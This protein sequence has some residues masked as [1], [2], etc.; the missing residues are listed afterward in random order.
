[1]T[2]DITS[3]LNTYNILIG[4]FILFIIISVITYKADLISFNAIFGKEFFLTLV[5]LIVISSII[6]E[7]IIFTSDPSNSLLRLLPY[8]TSPYFLPTIIILTGLISLG[9]FFAFLDISEILSKT[10]ENNTAVIV[11]LLFIILFI[12]ITIFTLRYSVNKDEKILN[13]LP[14]NIANAYRLRTY[15][16]I[17]FFVFVLLITLLY[18]VNPGNFM[19]SYG[20]PTIFFV[21]FI[22]LVM[23]AMITMYQYFL[24]NQS[25]AYL[26]DLIPGF[27]SFIIKGL[28]VVL[29]LAISGMLIYGL[30]QMLD[31][32]NQDASD[33]NNWTHYIFNFILLAS[34]LGILYKLIMAGGFIEKS[35]IFRLVVNTIMYIPCILVYLLSLIYSIFDKNAP[36]E[37]FA[38]ATKSEKILLGISVLLLSLYFIIDRLLVPFLYKKITTQGGK[39]YINEPI[40][41]DKQTNIA[42]YQILNNV[43]E[44]DKHNYNFALSFWFYIDSFPPSTNTSYT[45]VV[46]ILS[47]GDN[48]AIKYDALN[49]TLFVSVKQST[50]PIFNYIRENG[51]DINQQNLKNWKHVKLN[52]NTN[53]NTNDNTNIDDNNERIIYKTPNVLLQ[54]W[55]NITINSTGGTLDIFYNGELV[56]SATEVVPYLKYDML[57]VGNEKGISG[58]LANLVYFTNPISA[59]TISNIYNSLKDKN[60]PIMTNKYL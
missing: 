5:F 3:K 36:S 21:L 48:P 9:G 4:V 8:N 54:K 59:L 35:P 51:I 22:G 30:L 31:I 10:P 49:N 11:N 57:T 19:V 38:P 28:Y 33:Y 14:S 2:T 40:S 52:Y 55:N 34:L 1:M 26:L 12:V 32:F 15:W 43:V 25:Q 56:K 16:T 17:I 24:S 58:S 41:I 46:N 7:T 42:S 18:F 47:L 13:I 29:A 45:K 53:D 23:L 39:Q 6:K 44:P 20:K 37:K 50:N 27:A 60:P